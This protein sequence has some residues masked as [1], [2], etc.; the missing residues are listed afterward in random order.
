MQEQIEAKLAD[1]KVSAVGKWRLRQR[2]GLVRRLITGGLRQPR[3]EL[4]RGL[5][6]GLRVIPLH[7]AQPLRYN[8][9]AGLGGGVS[10]AVWWRIPPDADTPII[11]GPTFTSTGEARTFVIEP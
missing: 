2:A 8:T 11:T 3:R 6:L 7:R 1:G 9:P 10:D 4:E 5:P